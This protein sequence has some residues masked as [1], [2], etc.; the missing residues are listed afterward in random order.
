MTA[1]T[2]ERRDPI[3]ILR[4]TAGENRFH[5]E[6]FELMVTGRRYTAEE[7]IAAGIVAE[8]AAEADV[9]DRAVER[10]TA[11]AG[12]PPAGVEAIKRGLHGETIA[13]LEGFTTVAEELAG[14]LG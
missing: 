3:A 11:L 9:L 7:A 10:A 2:L 6:S 1:A 14:R 13:R 5:P 12:K 8:K 4:L